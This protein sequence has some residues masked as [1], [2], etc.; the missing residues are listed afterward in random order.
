MKTITEEQA[1]ALLAFLDAFEQT[2][3]GVWGAIEEHMAEN[4]GI[5]DPE[6]AVEAARNALQQ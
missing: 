3:T 2:T 5:D 6:A 1:Q 4:W